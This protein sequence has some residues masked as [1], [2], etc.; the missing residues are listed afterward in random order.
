M[1]PPAISRRRLLVAGAA[2]TACPRAP[3]VVTSDRERPGEPLAVIAGDIGTTHAVVWSRC[4]RPAAMLVEWSAGGVTGRVVG[5]VVGPG[6]DF[7]GRVHLQDLPPGRPIDYTVR[8]QDLTDPRIL[9]A[10]AH[11]R[12]R[13]APDTPRD[14]TLLWSG[15]TAG[16]GWGI[17]PAH[18]GMLTYAS[19]LAR[20]PDLFVHCGD[21][22]YADNPIPAELPLPGGGVWRNRTLAG[23]DKVAETLDEFR[24]AYRYNLLD[25]HYRRF[26]AAVPAVFA[27]DDHE[28]LN[29]WYPGERLTDPRY[30]ERDVSRLAERARQAFRDYTPI[31]APTIHRV[32]RCGP[33]VDL[34][35]LD[36]RSFRGPNTPGL[37]DIHSDTTAF[38]GRAQVEWLIDALR[39]SRAR[40]KILVADQPLG[41]VVPDDGA[42]EALANGDGGPPRGRELELAALLSALRRAGLSDLVWI[43]ADVH[44]A[45]AHRYDPARA[46]TPDF[47]PF[48]EFVAGPLHAGTFGPQPLDP[49]FGPEVRFQRAPPPGEANLPPSAG[50]QFFGEINAPARGPL[51][52]TLRDRLGE[53]LWSTEIEPATRTG[54]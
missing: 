49:T 27:W 43:T 21:L 14:F 19:M 11:G 25:D 26:H 30:R 42:I 22:I 40:W 37:E 39:T 6:T 16:Q 18:G 50:L 51:R 45:A 24:L 34:F 1:R 36:M 9:S 31:L 12:L 10:P 47:D 54:P 32:V 53:V 38:L 23:R 17:D 52:V 28:V 13:T 5:P 46:R 48:W 35:V 29:N 7:T 44:Y 3:A 41:L 20:D 15:D 4:D 33:L 8:F 2:L